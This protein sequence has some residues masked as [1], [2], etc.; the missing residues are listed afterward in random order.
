M[1][2]NMYEMT[3]GKEGVT[4][5]PL[6]GACEHEC[7]YCYVMEMKAKFRAH[8]E[9]YTGDIRLHPNGLKDMVR[10]IKPNDGR[11]V[12]VCSCHDLFSEGVPIEHIK[13]ILAQ[14]V[15]YPDNR[16]WFQSKNPFRFMQFKDK[17]PPHSIFCTTIE[18]N[19]YENGYPSKAPSPFARY[20]NLVKVSNMGFKPVAVTIEPIMDSNIQRLV[21][22]MI[23]LD[24]E[25][26]H[27]GADSKL[28]C[29][30]CGHTFKWLGK[31]ECPNC[32]RKNITNA[33]GHIEPSKVQVTALVRTLR[34]NGM[35]V[36]LKHNIY[37]ITGG[38]I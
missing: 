18:T 19:E 16:Y 29:V 34:E 15:Q 7:P 26:I 17:Y 3:S 14:L 24:P 37:R 8:R 5:N 20:E 31:V 9:K 36:I 11:N 30:D 21:D 25:I 22:W 12:F 1:T 10:K 2:S 27:I 23:A 28:R 4:V 35:N 13:T 33:H 6:A 38:E 32:R